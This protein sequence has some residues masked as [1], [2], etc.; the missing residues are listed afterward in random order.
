MAGGGDCTVIDLR[1][2]ITIRAKKITI[3]AKTQIFCKNMLCCR[4]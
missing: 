2:K 4:R 1:A 3:R